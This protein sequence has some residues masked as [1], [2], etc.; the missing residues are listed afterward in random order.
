M[1]INFSHVR[2]GNASVA[3]FDADV[4]SRSNKDRQQVLADLTTRAREVGLRVDRSVLVF[5][6]FGRQMFYGDAD[7]VRYLQKHPIAFQWTHKV[8]V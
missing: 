7:L 3:I 1:D 5:T 2:V 4:Q 8:S 6:Q